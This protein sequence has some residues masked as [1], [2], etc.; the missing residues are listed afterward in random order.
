MDERDF[1]SLCKTEPWINQPITTYE[2][3]DEWYSECVNQRWIENN[4]AINLRNYEE[5]PEK[6]RDR[7]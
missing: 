6:Y 2:A 4:R 1:I 3:Y 7:Y 5:R